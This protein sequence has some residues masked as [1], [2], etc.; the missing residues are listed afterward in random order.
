[1]GHRNVIGFCISI[2]YLATLLKLIVCSFF[3][4]FYGYKLR[5]HICQ[6]VFAFSNI[7]PL[8]SSYC[9]GQEQYFLIEAVI[10]IW[11]ICRQIGISLKALSSIHSLLKIYVLILW[12]WNFIKC[13]LST[14]L[15][16]YFFSSLFC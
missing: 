1:M 5:D 6:F 2:L 14:Y 10:Y 7:M 4:I 12:I 9:T 16:N 15:D 13:T 3:W 8:I 11:Y